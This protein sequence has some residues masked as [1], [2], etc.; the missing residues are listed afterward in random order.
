MSKKGLLKRNRLSK[1]S[2]FDE[3]IHMKELENNLEN[4]LSPADRLINSYNTTW[5]RSIDQ[6]YKE[7]IF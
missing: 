2:E 5:G 6:V 7:L 3:S 4:G 1:N